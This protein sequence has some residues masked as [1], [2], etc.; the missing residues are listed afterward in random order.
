VQIYFLTDCSVILAT[1]Y[2]LNHE[3]ERILPPEKEANEGDP[4]VPLCKKVSRML[5]TC[6]SAKRTSREHNKLKKL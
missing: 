6:V 4:K 1:N 5:A 2:K 3:E